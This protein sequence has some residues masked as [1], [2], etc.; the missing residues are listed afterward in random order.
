MEYI[1]YEKDEIV[2]GNDLIGKINRALNRSNLIK[3]KK[4]NWHS[5][6]AVA[7]NDFDIIIT[8]TKG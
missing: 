6:V 1:N 2:N 4:I 3:D 8:P 5:K 7:T